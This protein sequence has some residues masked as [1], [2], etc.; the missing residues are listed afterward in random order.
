MTMQTIMPDT[1]LEVVAE[2][3]EIDTRTVV[4]GRVHIAVTT[5]TV[6][7]PVSLTLNQTDVR[8]VRHEV[9]QTL[10]PDDPVPQQRTEG[11]TTIVPILEE[12]VV[13]ETRLVL[14]AEL[15]VTR[16][17][18]AE[19]FSTTVPLRHQTASVTRDADLT[20]SQTTAGD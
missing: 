6:D 3:L 10:G 15:H 13:V 8:V 11:D 20:L 14:R 18:T 4:T 7:Q 12:V 9:D 2:Q 19:T 1:A 16:I 17:T 5:Q